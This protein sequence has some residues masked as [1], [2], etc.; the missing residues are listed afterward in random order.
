MY[1][2]QSKICNTKYKIEEE[3]KEAKEAIRNFL[4]DKGNLTHLDD[5][6]P[7]R[8]YTA[9]YID[10]DGDAQSASY[11]TIELEEGNISV[12]LSDSHWLYEHE[13]TI[14]N[15]LDML[16]IIIDGNGKYIK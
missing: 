5:L 10:N 6:P 3:I 4:K 16:N 12:E 14:E 9:T 8:Q 2:H 1:H 13:L 15:I 7:H 11:R